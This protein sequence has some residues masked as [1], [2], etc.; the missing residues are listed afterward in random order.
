[1]GAF[2]ECT[3]EEGRGTGDAQVRALAEPTAG[4][5]MQAGERLVDR[6]RDWVLMGP[7]CCKG[8]WVYS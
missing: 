8:V 5:K 4:G 7:L 2:S 6:D 1:M 3:G